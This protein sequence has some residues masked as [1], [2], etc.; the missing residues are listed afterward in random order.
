M[1]Q[2]TLWDGGPAALNKSPLRYPGGKTRAVRC[3]ASFLPDD[4][5][6]VCSPFF[7]GGS[8]ELYLA[9]RGYRVR[10]YDA[11]SPLVRFWEFALRDAAGLA[12]VVSRRYPPADFGRELFYQLRGSMMRESN[13]LALAAKFYVLNRASYSGATLSGGMSPGHPRYNAEAIGR[14]GR[15]SPGGDVSVGLADFRDSIPMHEDAYLYLDP[16]YALDVSRLYGVGGDMHEG[17]SHEEL[18]GILLGR[19]RWVL[20]YN[21]CEL[22]RDLYD[23]CRVVEASWSYGMGG[24]K[25]GREVIVL[26]R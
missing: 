3:L 8:V 22:V 26:P 14:L 19:D 2:L 13:K 21:D 12:E 11:F 20:S 15:F 1:E 7:G 16:P 24:G 25:R 9:A 6:D 23:G 5:A 17:F 18:A 4:A 10:G